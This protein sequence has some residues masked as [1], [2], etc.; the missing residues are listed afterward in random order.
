M[1][2]N[3]QQKMWSQHKE[4]VL[5]LVLGLILASA[6]T[7]FFFFKRKNKTVAKTTPQAN[8]QATVSLPSRNAKSDQQTE[9]NIL[10]LG[11]GGA[12]HQGGSLTDVIQ[13]L[14]LNFETNQIALISIPRDL[15]VKLPNGRAAKINKA[16]TFENGAQVAKDMASVVTNLPIDYFVA[17]DF[18][19]FKRLIGQE[20]GGITVNIPQTLEDPWYPIQGEELNPCGKSPEKIAELTA[21]YNGFE[22]EKKF[23]CRYEH[24]YFPA[25]EMKLEGGEALKYVRSRHGS[26]GG[27]FDRSQRQQVVLSGIKDKLLTLDALKKAPTIFKQ[28]SPHIKT[29]LDLETIKYLLPAIEG[30]G[31]YEA[32]SIILST[33]NVLSTDKTN[34][35]QFTLRPKAGFSQWGPVHHFLQQQLAASDKAN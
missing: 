17:V 35:G 3:W 34:N 27:D 20:L 7:S 15:W 23:E 12:G 16:F 30:L 28:L 2:T 18:V 29:D 26:S 25:G 31:S 14:H 21:N 9:L 22:L 19:G 8:H 13:V 4:L 33:E 32:Q 1:K 5:A 11:Y 24:L 6:I 10:L